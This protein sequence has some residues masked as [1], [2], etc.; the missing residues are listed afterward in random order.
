LLDSRA[1]TLLDR[2]EV[3]LRLCDGTPYIEQ[4]EI[5]EQDLVIDD[6]LLP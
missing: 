2:G 5:D 6:D 4:R 1:L 3:Y